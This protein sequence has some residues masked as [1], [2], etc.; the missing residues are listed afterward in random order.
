MDMWWPEGELWQ[1]QF[2]VFTKFGSS[3][4]WH[5]AKLQF[6]ASPFP[7]SW[8]SKW[9]SDLFWPME[10]E[11]KALCAVIWG[12]NLRL[13][14]L[15]DGRILDF[16]FTAWRRTLWEEHSARNIHVRFCMSKRKTF[17]VLAIESWS[18]F[19]TAASLCWLIQTSFLEAPHYISL[20]IHWPEPDHLLSPD[21]FEGGVHS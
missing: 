12:P 21:S 15:H 20:Y 19:V 18:M 8:V 10:C 4:S 13:A 2:L 11:E 1:G 6:P 5:R 16:W 3:S 7:G 17:V 9:P 14:E